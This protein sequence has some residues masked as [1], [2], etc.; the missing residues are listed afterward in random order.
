MDFTSFKKLLTCFAD[1][2]A[3]IDAA[4]G[5]LL[6]EIRDEVIEAALTQE[7]GEIW[8]EEF[9]ERQR[10]I[11]W[12]LNRVARLPVLADRILT[13]FYDPQFFVDPRAEILDQIGEQSDSDEIRRGNAVQLTLDGLGKRP[14]GSSSVLYLT[15]DAGEGKTTLIMHLA[16]T[17]AALFKQ[18]QVDWLLVPISLGG[19]PF[20]RFDDIVVGFLTNRL[21][22]PLFYFEAFIE[23]VKLGVIIPAFDGFEEMFVQNASGDALSAVGN[24]MR[25]LESSGTVLIAARKAYFEYQDVRTQ[26]K[27]FDSI[28]QQ[29]VVFSRVELKRWGRSEFLY[30]CN[31]RSIPEAESIYEKVTERLGAEHPLLTRAVLVKRLIDVAGSVASLSEL[32]EKIGNSPTDYFKVFVEAIVEREANEKWIDTSGQPARP[33]LSVAEH[34]ELLSA[35][36]EEMWNLSTDLLKADVLDLVAEMFCE[37]RNMAPAKAFQVKERTKQHALIVSSDSG[38]LSFAFDH[39]EFK[40]FFLGEAIGRLG[41]QNSTGSA[42]DLLTLLRRGILPDQAVQA[43]IT[44]LRRLAPPRREEVAATLQGVAKLDSPSSFTHENVSRLILGVLHEIECHGL[45]ITHINFPPDSFRDLQLVGVVFRD[46]SFAVTSLEHTKLAQIRFENCR[47]Q[48]IQIFP[49]TRIL[50]C[51]LDAQCELNGVIPAGKESPVFDPTAFP[52]LLSRVGFIVE[53]AAEQTELTLDK[54]E[55]VELRH[56]RKLMRHFLRSTHINENVVLRK[57]GVG[58]EE[59]IKAAIPRLKEAGVII[60]EWIARDKQH[61]YRLSASMERV[62]ETIDRA[63]GSFD[64]FLKLYR[65]TASSTASPP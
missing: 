42:N 21:R 28:G 2:P 8:I 32:L 34:F 54:E 61:R 25:T 5:R 15:S 18:K 47:F 13:A 49:S 26:A 10:A 39:E 23:L 19:R 24:L 3:S 52:V 46:C 41:V 29:S 40:N 43:A 1:S 50:E 64:R 31:N 33:L 36:A 22:F 37:S 55:D 20:L 30:Y 48:R 38:K 7:M 56:L 60:E 65:D 57:L 12:I 35:I 63:E 6:C 59:F 44:H 14:V 9:G 62:H 45:V 11:S 16:R 51:S 4:R 27:L 17:Q 58:A 53:R